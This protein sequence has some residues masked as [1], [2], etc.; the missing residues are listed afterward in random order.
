M[1]VLGH[2]FGSQVHKIDVLRIFASE[3]FIYG[4]ERQ[5]YT[6]LP[7]H[8][9]THRDR[10]RETEEIRNRQIDSQR[11]KLNLNVWRKQAFRNKPKSC[12]TYHFSSGQKTMYSR[13]F[14]HKSIAIFF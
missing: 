9:P 13:L 6:H 14:S 5:T 12:N 1:K 4:A 8:L 10:D 3:I 7:T 2:D 11:E